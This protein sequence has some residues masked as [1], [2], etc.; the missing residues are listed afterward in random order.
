MFIKLFTGYC[1]LGLHSCHIYIDILH[2]NSP[3]TRGAF[4]TF[5]SYIYL[6]N[7]KY[8]LQTF[9]LSFSYHQRWN[10]RKNGKGQQEEDKFDDLSFCYPFTIRL[11]SVCYPFAIPSFCYPFRQP[12]FHLLFLC[13]FPLFWVWKEHSEFYVNTTQNSTTSFYLSLGKDIC[14][15][16][17]NINNLSVCWL[18]GLVCPRLVCRRSPFPK[19]SESYS[20]ML[21][22]EQLL[23][24]LIYKMTNAP[25]FL[26][27][28]CN[29]YQHAININGRTVTLLS[30]FH[31]SPHFWAV[32]KVRDII[33]RI[34]H[35]FC[36]FLLI[37]SVL[38]ISLLSGYKQYNNIII[39]IIQTYGFKN[40]HTFNIYTDW[41]SFLSLVVCRL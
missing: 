34:S 11:V 26:H 41:C 17:L 31:F 7:I 10:P 2:S 8:V 19:T 9:N 25:L 1:L 36:H 35:I 32:A 5:K 21:W 24:F 3:H 29:T 37:Q 15:R 22:S 20:S 28:T 27:Y 18:G 38:F 40:W 6:S 30:L 33:D 16:K 13:L 12:G 14:V 23:K 4:W 39:F